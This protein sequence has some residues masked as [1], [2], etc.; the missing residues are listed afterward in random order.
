M[1]TNEGCLSSAEHEQFD[2]SVRSLEE[3]HHI[4]KQKNRVIVLFPQIKLKSPGEK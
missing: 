4:G 3:S 2:A 1:N